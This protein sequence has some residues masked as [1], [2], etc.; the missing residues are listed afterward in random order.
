[1]RETGMS[2]AEITWRTH[3]MGTDTEADLKAVLR[4]LRLAKA[5]IQLLKKHFA[6]DPTKTTEIGDLEVALELIIKK[7]SATAS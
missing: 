7:L 5:Q 6:N 3:S 1:M 4:T 2:A